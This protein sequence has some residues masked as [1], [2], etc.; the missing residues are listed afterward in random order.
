MNRAT[1]ES[2]AQNVIQQAKAR[3][4][5]LTIE[6]QARAT[7]TKLAAQ[8]EA[9]ATRIRAETEA[10]IRNDFAQS[11]ARARLEV[12]RTRAH[13]E[14]GNVIFAP[15]EVL[16]NGAMAFDVWPAGQAYVAVKKC[17]EIFDI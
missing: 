5:A 7:A 14:Q 2:D 17:F 1:A 3:A 9:D 11:L 15:L 10:S 8:A 6:A 12:E 4:E 16:N 13:G